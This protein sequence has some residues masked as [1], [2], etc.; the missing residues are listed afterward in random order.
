MRWPVLL[1]EHPLALDRFDYT[2]VGEHGAL[3][4]VL[5]RVPSELGEPAGG[6][7][8]A[9][10]RVSRSQR[11]WQSFVARGCRIEAAQSDGE[12][13]WRGLFAVPFALVHQPAFGFELSAP[14]LPALTL[15]VPS[16][17]GALALMAAPLGADPE[18]AVTTVDQLS[19]EQVARLTGSRM[20]TRAVA[21]ATVLAVTASSTPAGAI[22]DAGF[23]PSSHAQVT[24]H[25]IENYVHFALERAHAEAARKRSRSSART[26]SA[27][28]RTPRARTKGG[29]TGSLIH[30]PTGT[31]TGQ[32]SST[33]RCVPGSAA[34]LALRIRLAWAARSAA[35]PG[36]HRAVL[37][38]WP[39]VVPV[40]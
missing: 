3:L 16:L 11:P 24:Q 38:R 21:L 40:G 23:G 15:P 20:R 36:T 28:R 6:L 14:G 5:A 19:P 9:E 27:T 29:L 30:Q 39:V 25:R 8:G 13:I 17:R 37:L 32:R 7:T 34:D 33:A 12:L 2:R 31:T 10:L 4:R 1:L 35:D 26:R 22:A 18:L